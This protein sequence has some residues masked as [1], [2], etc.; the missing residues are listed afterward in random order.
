[1]GLVNF[2][3]HRINIL[4]LKQ[5]IRVLVSGAF[6]KCLSIVSIQTVRTAKTAHALVCFKSVSLRFQNKKSS[7]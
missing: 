3:F 4:G 1:M 2:V 6:L 7:F 5:E